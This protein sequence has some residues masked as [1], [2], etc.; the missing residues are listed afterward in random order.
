MVDKPIKTRITEMFGC[1]YPIIQGGLGYLSRAELA[2][3]VSNAG[4]M[5]IITSHSVNTP[6]ELGDELR[7]AKTLT[8]KP[9]GVNISLFPMERE[10]DTMGM[11]D[12]CMEEGVAFVET[13]GR[14][15]DPVVERVR[16]SGS[17]IKTIHKTVSSRFAVHAEHLGVDAVTM[18]GYEGGGHPG[19]E[20]IAASVLIPATV[21]K[22]RIPVIA[23]GGINDARG[24]VAALVWGAE[25]VLLGTRF[26]ATK[27]CPCH[28]NLKQWLVRATEK[29]TMIIDRSIRSA[30]RVLRNAPAERVLGM[31]QI[32]ASLAEQL[33]VMSGAMS[34]KVWAEG[35]IDEGVISSGQGVGLIHDVPTVKEVI[36][37]IIEG[38][39]A[40]KERLT[41]IGVF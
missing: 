22:V 11:V 17:N 13:I 27:E 40:I 35:K 38:V 4:G 37:S 39:A 31:Q 14:S 29:D 10:F 21:E 28:E 19:M 9:F 26:M 7:K 34:A 15:P 20:E 24:F 1:K 18:V 16:R 25:G 2:A 12:V 33:D 23:A 5:G 30:R 8:D 6:K 32:D 36:D 41:S 3:A